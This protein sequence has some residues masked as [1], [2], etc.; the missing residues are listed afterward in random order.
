MIRGVRKALRFFFPGRRRKEAPGEDGKLTAEAAEL[1]GRMGLERLAG[2]VRVTWNK[3]MRSTAGRAF[4]PAGR[5]ELNPGLRE[6]GGEVVARTLRHELA[7]LAAYA[8]AGRRRVSPHGAEWRAACAELGIPGESVTHDLPLK[9]NVVRR[10]WR[11][12]CPACGE[13]VERVRRMRGHVACYPCCRAHS[14]GRYDRRFALL[15]SRIRGT[16]GGG[17]DRGKG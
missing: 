5:V 9:G 2:R 8:R 12:A 10:N 16:G 15:E 13:A 4:W 11:Y 14:G 3:R 6:L 7:H 17:R 1:L